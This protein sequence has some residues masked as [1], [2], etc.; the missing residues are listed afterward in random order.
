[1]PAD[2]GGNPTLVVPDW[3][4]L[5]L[6]FVSSGVLR[7]YQ[8]E[9]ATQSPLVSS[10]AFTGTVLGADVD[11]VSGALFINRGPSGSGPSN[12]TPVYRFDPTTLTETG[13]Y[14]SQSTFPSYPTSFWLGQSVVCVQSGSVGYSFVKESAFSGFVGAFR[15][16]TLLNAGFHTQVVS[17]STNNRGFMCRGASGLAGGSVFLSWDST[18]SPSA[19]IPLY[20]ITIAPGASAYNP[21]SW[22]TPN[23]DIT[24]ATIGTIPAASVDATWTHLACQS[25]GY[26]ETDGNVLM[27]VSTNDAV[28][29]KNYL[30]KVNAA[31]AAVMWATILP[32]LAGPS[33]VGLPSYSVNNDVAGLLGTAT[34]SLVAADTGG[35]GTS[36]LAGLNLA[37][38]GFTVGGQGNTHFIAS[39]TA[40]LFMIGAGY[41][42]GAGAPVPVAGTP[43]SFTGFALLGGIIPEPPPAQQL[44]SLADLWFG[45]TA[46]FV[47]LRATSERRKFIGID[48]STQFLGFNG[49]RPFGAAPPVFLTLGAGQAA[50]HFADNLGSG[51]AFVISGGTLAID[52]APP[53]SGAYTI[54]A[55]V[56]PNTPQGA[57]PQIMLSVSDDGGRTFSL[58][59]KWRSLG[60]IGEY[61]KRLR[62]LKMGQFRQRQIRLEVTDPVRRNI[63][64]VYTSVSEGE[65]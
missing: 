1:M 53:P 12:G 59:Q 23:P 18:T 8:I 47:D 63:V 29:H 64:G 27:V 16:D 34:S 48:A 21:A 35:I 37:N 49:E 58:L 22:P 13:H 24:S 17:G 40:A 31:T 54:A 45:A 56:L 62:W 28:T 41:T 5:R 65:P 6:Y 39:D 7:S 52:G 14:G 2:G 33:L 46:S 55:G 44:A 60:K 32:T 20:K 25:I 19:T 42:A 61:T 38:A 3:P 10:Q 15:C 50:D 26:D 43:S 57:D 51:G 9:L 4:R 11:P 30:I 36:A